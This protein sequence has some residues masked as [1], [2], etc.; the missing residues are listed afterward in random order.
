MPT[1]L[2]FL[3]GHEYGIQN[4]DQETV[5]TAN[6]DTVNEQVSNTQGQDFP[7]FPGEAAVWILRVRLRSIPDIAYQVFPLDL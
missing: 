1:G 2:V 5:D 3:Y 6:P 7:F 4:G